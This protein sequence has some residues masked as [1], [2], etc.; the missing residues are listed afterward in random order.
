MVAR[1]AREHTAGRAAVDHLLAR[2]AREPQYPTQGAT[3][4]VDLERRDLRRAYTPR[5]V[6]ETFLEG[7]GANM[8]YLYNLLDPT[9]PVEKVFVNGKL[10]YRRPEAAP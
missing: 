10:A 7:R 4:F 5:Q 2:L 9:T 6:V 3:L 8:F 1:L